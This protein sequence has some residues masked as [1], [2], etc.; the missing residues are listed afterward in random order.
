[1]KFKVNDSKEPFVSTSLQGYIDITHAELIEKLGPTGD[2]FDDYKCDAEWTIH[3]EDGTVATIYNYKDG[4][5]YL[6][7][8]GDEVED[9][10]D[11]HIGGN[12]KSDV[13]AVKAIFGKE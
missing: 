6:G 12:S 8:E 1:M 7:A 13:E 4:K 11:W 2:D 3:F 9:I 10:T 5:N